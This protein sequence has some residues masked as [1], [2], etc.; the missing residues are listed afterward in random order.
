MVCSDGS[1]ECSIY[2]DARVLWGREEVDMRAAS[3][4]SCRARRRCCRVLLVQ[5][6]LEVVLAR[7][8]GVVWRGIV[9]VSAAPAADQGWLLRRRR[10]RVVV[11]GVSN[12]V[13][14][15]R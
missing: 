7:S 10:V 14:V 11:E 3:P 9:S 6:K 2:S 15:S 1:G 12:G 13:A 4:A 8:G 5:A